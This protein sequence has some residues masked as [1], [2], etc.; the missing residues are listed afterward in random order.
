MSKQLAT[1][2]RDVAARTSTSTQIA[3]QR[4]RPLAA[5]RGVPR[6]RAARPAAAARGG[7]GRRGGR[8]RRAQ[9]GDERARG[10]APSEVAGVELATADGGRARRRWPPSGPLR[11]ATAVPTRAAG[12]RRL[13]GR[14]RGAGGRGRDAGRAHAGLGRAARWSRTTGRRSRP[15]RTRATPPPLEHDTMVA[16][17]LIDPAR[18][19]YPLDEL[20][21]DEGIE[22]RGRGRRTAPRW[23]SAR[24]A[25]AR[26]RSASAAGSRSRG[27][28]GCFD[29]VE[30]PLVEVLVDM[31]RA[32]RQARHRAARRDQRAASRERIASSSARSGSWRARSSRS[33]RRSSSARSCSRSSACR[34]KRRGKTGFSTDARVLAAIRD[35]HEIIGKVEQWRELSQAQEHLPR[36]PARADHATR[37]GAST[38]P[39][40]RRPP[41]RAGCRAPTPTSR[42]SRSARE[43]GREIRACFVAEEGARLISADYSQVELRVL[44]HIADEQVLK[45]IFEARRGRA[46][47]HRRRDVRAAARAGR[48]RHALARPR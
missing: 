18:R 28:R 40:T 1:A 36:R 2:V 5:A 32:G 43:Q 12:L 42:T 8:R 10:A 4:A 41:P 37:T 17:Y 15:A 11:R 35:E 26:W 23:P 6:V 45:D 13:R 19:Q 39:S 14:R 3:A 21:E 38:P 44:A 48:T 9:R 31:E 27:S 46:R 22:R 30:L 24:C 33:A 29:E 16:A 25:R 47:R 34:R 7:A 20:L